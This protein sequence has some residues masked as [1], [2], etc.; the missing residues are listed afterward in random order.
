[1]RC[2]SGALA[3]G[4]TQVSTDSTGAELRDLHCLQQASSSLSV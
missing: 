1:V 4:A 3:V 2:S